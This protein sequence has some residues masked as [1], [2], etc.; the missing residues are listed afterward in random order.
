MRVLQLNTFYGKVGGAEIYMHNVVD[1]LREAGHEVGVFAFSPDE[2]IDEPNVRVVQRPEF[3]AANL[4]RDEAVS[5]ALREFVARF[6]P[7]LIHCHNLSAYAAD[8][9]LVL[10]SF[11]KPMMQTVH[12]FSIL[13]PN[14]WCVRPDGVVCE[15]GPGEKCFQ[16]DCQKNYPYDGRVVTASNLR[17]RY[18]PGTFQAFLSPSQF[19]AD[20]LTEHGF[21]N[22]ECLPL[23]VDLEGIPEEALTG[24]P[25]RDEDHVL[26]L[27]RLVPEKGVAYL[28][29]AM[30]HLLKKRPGAKLS[31]VGGGPQLEELKAQAEKLGL[32][33]AI[34][35][36]GRV[37]H[38]EVQRFF[39]TATLQVLPS[40]WCENSPVT[41]Y[42][43]FI[44]G[45]PM[46]ASRI[47]GLP[48]MVREG[49]TGLLAEPRNAVD[50]ADKIATMLGDKELRQ[51]LSRGCRASLDRYSKAK[52]MKRL[53]EV[54]DEVLARAAE[55]EPAAV[56]DGALDLLAGLD[57]FYKENS[58]LEKWAGDMKGHIDYLESTGA[59]GKPVQRFGKHLYFMAKSRVRQWR[60]KR[61]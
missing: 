29:E 15:G 16:H 35:F 23:W 60:E 3:T 34:V 48:A 14:S 7:D 25:E 24:E 17:Y 56:P 44:S 49:E 18:V 41:I 51:E 30:P 1:A 6:D 20:K 32:G 58:K 9:A 46:V 12:D 21:E 45:L 52:H 4:V 53:L 11:G 39:S 26:F 19:L 31:V 5:S 37:P 54:Y 57:S 47:A 59:A 38:E 55:S 2:A 42:E 22:S 50:L 40:I 28:V 36:H 13:C 33:D 8:L 43:S 61:G 27:G 10:R